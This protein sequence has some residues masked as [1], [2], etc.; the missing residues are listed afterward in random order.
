MQKFVCICAYLAAV[1]SC[2][3]FLSGCQ[4]GDKP[5]MRAGAWFGPPIVMTFPAPAHL[6]KH[7]YAF[8]LGE[9][10]GMLYTCRGGFIDLAHVREAADRTAYLAALAYRNIMLGK[11][12]FS[13]VVIEPSRYWVT[14]SYPENWA[15][16]SAEDKARTAK[17]V[18]LNMGQ[19]LA[20][21]TLI[22]HEIITWYGYASTGLVSERISSFSWE[23]TYSD[24]LGIRLAAQAMNDD[25]RG[26]DD[27]MTIA[28]DQELQDLDVQP[29]RVA[30]QATETVLGKWYVTRLGLFVQMEM[31]N[32]DVGQYDGRITPLLVPGICADAQPQPLPNPSMDIASLHGFAATVQMEPRIWERGRIYR[33][34]GLQD[35]RYR[36]RPDTDYPQIIAHLKDEAWHGNVPNYSLEPAADKTLH[37]RK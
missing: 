4:L 6:G 19:Y 1:L 37:V 21:T 14:I 15:E 28:L 27:A 34:I 2:V 13:F 30:R 11:T 9:A 23:D 29:A 8:S 18:S 10:N 5:R 31:W 35:A 12:E 7:S 25:Q 26:F 32:F 20:H 22:W 36:I 17:D 33:D 16:L 3:V 24:L